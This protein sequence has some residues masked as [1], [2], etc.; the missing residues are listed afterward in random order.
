MISN[1]LNRLFIITDAQGIKIFSE[2]GSKQIKEYDEDYLVVK[3]VNKG[4]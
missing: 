1:K 2:C 4:G 3:I